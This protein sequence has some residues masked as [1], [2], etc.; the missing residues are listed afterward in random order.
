MKNTKL[1][2]LIVKLKMQW[3]PNSLIEI[4]FEKKHLN[5]PSLLGV[6]VFL[7]T[8]LKTLSFDMIDSADIVKRKMR[9]GYR[10]RMV[11]SM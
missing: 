8:Q 2:E 11:F 5:L 10:K 6:L 3:F 1:K 9:Y 7:A 4:P